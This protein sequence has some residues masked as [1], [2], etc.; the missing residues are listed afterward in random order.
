MERLASAYPGAETFTFGDGPDLC[1]ALLAAARSGA[2]T[3]TCGA[4]RDFEA[5]EPMPVVGRRD[6]ALDRDGTPALV[7]E[8]TEVTL[9]RFRDVPEGIAL[10]EGEGTF[11]EWRMGHER[12]FARNGGYDPEMMLVCERFRLLED[13][14]AR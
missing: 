2:K 12:F 1:A 4:L 9:V 6:I 7:I 14:D 13:L 5:G 8:T 3:A 10:A 11:E